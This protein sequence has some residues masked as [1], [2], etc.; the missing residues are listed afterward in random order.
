ME[1]YQNVI[2]AVKTLWEWKIS[3][4][5]TALI[6]AIMTSTIMLLMPN[7]YR[8]TTVFY[9]INSDLLK[10]ITTENNAS[11]YFGN[12]SDADRILSIGNS[13]ELVQHLIQSFS[14]QEHYQIKGTDKK[15]QAKVQKRFRKLYDIKKTE[16]DAIQI[17]MED[18]ETDVARQ[19]AQ[20][21][22]G[23]IDQKNKEIA[24]AAQKMMI[25]SLETSI[26][27]KGSELGDITNK[28]A[29]LRKKYG[30]YDTKSQGEA[31]AKMEAASPSSGQ[32]RKKIESYNAGVSDILQLEVKQEALSKSLA[33]SENQLAD[34]QGSLA[35]EPSTL[36]LIEEAQ[37]PLEK[38][39]PRRSLYV[40]GAVIF[41]TGIAKLLILLMVYGGFN[42]KP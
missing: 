33:Y 12:D 9:P 30:V 37:I 10:P 22:R 34:L 2:P 36:H 5:A 13:E 3:L 24:Q 25:S 35:Q 11:G 15:A 32:V 17:S 4:F 16:Y 29:E 28:L 27:N 40:I 21:A 39:R 18:R 1:N 14:L 42:S 26:Q 31:L 41:V 20:A 19:L 8:S 6:T 23:F 7:Y 38:S